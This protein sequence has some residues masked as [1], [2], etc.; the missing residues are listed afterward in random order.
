MICAAHGPIFDAMLLCH[1][2]SMQC[3]DRRLSSTDGEHCACVL[4]GKM[5]AVLP[6]VG[7]ILEATKDSKSYRPSNPWVRDISF[8]ALQKPCSRFQ[9]Q[10]NEA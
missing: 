5:I 4:Q 1:V 7:K 3:T 8:K 9:A 6:F 2:R 10:K